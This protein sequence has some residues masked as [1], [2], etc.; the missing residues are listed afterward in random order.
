[1]TTVNPLARGL[2]FLGGNDSSSCVH[3]MVSVS[4][5]AACQ[6]PPSCCVQSLPVCLVWSFLTMLVA[7]GRRAWQ[8]CKIGWRIFRLREEPC[9]RFCLVKRALDC[10]QIVVASGILGVAR[11]AAIGANRADHSS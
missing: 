4:F 9:Q 7:C 11:S 10:P 2:R 8:R 1:M 6:E 3:I 5:R